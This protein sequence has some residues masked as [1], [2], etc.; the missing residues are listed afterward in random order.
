[1]AEP[2]DRL[3]PLNAL[4][5]FEAAA[6]RLSFTQAADELN[7][8]PGAISQ[9]IRQLED[10]AGTPLFKRTGRSVLLTDAAQASL[11]LVREAFERISEAGRIMQSPA[12]K[13]RVMVSCAP[14][15][16][17][18]WLAPRLDKFHQQHGGIEAW[19][20]ADTG[21]TDFTTADADFAIRYGRGSYDGLKSEK[22]LD[23]T[24]L[25][26]CSPAMLDGPDAI[27]RPEDLKNHTLLHDESTEVDP[28]CPDWGSWL[29]A[30]KVDGV[31]AS[32]GPRF[33]QA[34]L[35]I[36][37][38]AAGRGVALAKQA[39]AASD[40][41]SGRLVAPFADGSTSIDFGYWLVWP[42]GR[43]LSPD[44]REFIKWIKAEAAQTE[45]VGV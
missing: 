24:V 30:R 19:I 9:Q 45:V 2:T 6:R 44:V 39:I 11:P 28:S 27:R 3:P 37:A 17:A 18:K 32:R 34:I 7:V 35:V 40:L 8:T 22:L 29:R 20:S 43:H 26:V 14:S 38:A 16:A 4:R 10:Y 23:E 1:M 41:A 12:R 15:F 42:K 25:P 36:E 21:L 31:D 33:N 5:A 13:G